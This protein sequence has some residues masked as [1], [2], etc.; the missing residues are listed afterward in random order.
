MMRPDGRTDK[1]DAGRPVESREAPAHVLRWLVMTRT[2]SGRSG[3]SVATMSTRQG[4]F[5]TNDPYQA[6]EQRFLY[7]RLVG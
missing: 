3:R 7:A 6:A 2:R 4:S 1:V 5:F